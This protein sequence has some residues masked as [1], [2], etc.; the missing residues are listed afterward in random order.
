MTLAH[1]NMAAELIE[2]YLKSQKSQQVT[3]SKDWTLKV[4]ETL[5]SSLEH[6]RAWTYWGDR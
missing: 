1:E 4:M 6:V 5:E 2:N 3:T